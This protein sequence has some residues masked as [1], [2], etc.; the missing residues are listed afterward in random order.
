MPRHLRVRGFRRDA[1]LGWRVPSVAKITHDDLDALAERGLALDDPSP[2]VAELVEAVDQSRLADPGDA[3]HALLLAADFSEQSGDLPAALALAERAAALPAEP[4]F[5]RACYAELL[6]KSGR[7]EEGRKAFEAVRPQLLQDLMAPEYLGDTLEACGLASL[8]EQWLG[9][10]AR[11]LIAGGES[12]AAAVEMVFELVKERHRL[13][14]TLD[15][16]HDDLDDLYH[17]LQAAIET[18]LAGESRALL[19]WPAPE[20]TKLLARWPE[21]AE[22]FGSDWDEHRAGVELA[23]TGWSQAGVMGVGLLTGS[24]D[25]LVAFAAAEDADPTDEETLGDF[26]DDVA[27]RLGAVDWPPQRNAPCWCGS[28]VKYKK[29]CLPRSRA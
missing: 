14:E 25:D 4:G 23:L 6:V 20:F 2:V 15:L 16:G 17:E 27:D 26:A 10:A 7:E 28:A 8:G 9:E 1:G 29:C 19:F 22:T 3:E 13:R 21:Q 5:A 24:V 12:D 11:S 18:S